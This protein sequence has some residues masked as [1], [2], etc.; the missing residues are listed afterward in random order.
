MQSVLEGAD[1]FRRITVAQR[2]I[3]A[4]K[5]RRP[6]AQALSRAHGSRRTSADWPAAAAG[7]RSLCGS[8]PTR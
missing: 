4:R 3:A 6:G 8:R 1:G 5:A 7:W 2:G